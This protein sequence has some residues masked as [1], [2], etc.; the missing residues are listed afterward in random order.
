M[1]PK[2]G[3]VTENYINLSPKNFT[4]VLSVL[5]LK[6]EVHFG[7]ADVSINYLNPSSHEG[8]PEVSEYFS[9]HQKITKL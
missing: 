5:I 9:Y 4:H 7:I 6:R 1:E 2:L 8:N 3:R